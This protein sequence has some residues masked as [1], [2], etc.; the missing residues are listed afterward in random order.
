MNFVNNI[1]F[2]AT[3][4]IVSVNYLAENYTEFQS[5]L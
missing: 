1:I 3:I 5:I 4:E 2:E